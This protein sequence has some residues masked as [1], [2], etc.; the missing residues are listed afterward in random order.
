VHFD[1]PRWGALSAMMGGT[2]SASRAVEPADAL[3]LGLSAL[4]PAGWLPAQLRSH[5]AKA[6]AVVPSVIDER[7][8]ATWAA[9]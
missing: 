7:A 9:D 4:G 6:L 2:A 1:P 8:W 5:P 3:D